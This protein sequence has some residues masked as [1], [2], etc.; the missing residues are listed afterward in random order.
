MPAR[1]TGHARR[2]IIS[3]VRQAPTVW[4][5]AP[6]G[7][8]ETV[9]IPAGTVLLTENGVVTDGDGAASGTWAAHDDDRGAELTIFNGTVAGGEADPCR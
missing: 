8:S 1:P 2:P 5:T 7:T 9:T 6:D 4:K 3:S